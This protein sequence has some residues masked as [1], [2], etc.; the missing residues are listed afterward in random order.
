V[1]ANDEGN[2]EAKR[3]KAAA[4]SELGGGRRAR[5]RGTTICPPRSI[6]CATYPPAD[7][8][9][10]DQRAGKQGSCV[11]TSADILGHPD[12]KTWRV[13]NRGRWP[14]HCSTAQASRSKTCETTSQSTRAC[15]VQTPHRRR[16]RSPDGR[17]RGSTASFPRRQ[18]LRRSH[19]GGA[20]GPHQHDRRV[21]ETKRRRGFV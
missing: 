1:L 18:T 19:T 16:D 5:S 6:C 2:V 3:L 4:L 15:R 14:T 20:R 9:E 11:D 21:L 12:C 17:A 10:V 13:L 7:A 8:H